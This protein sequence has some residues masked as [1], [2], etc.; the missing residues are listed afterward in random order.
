MMNPPSTCLQSWQRACLLWDSRLLI[1]KARIKLLLIQ[2]QEFHLAAPTFTGPHFEQV[3][4]NIGFGKMHLIHYF[5]LALVSG[6]WHCTLGHTTFKGNIIYMQQTQ[7]AVTVNPQLVNFH[8]RFDI[9]MILV[10]LDT[11]DR[12]AAAYH[13]FC[14]EA[15][16]PQRGEFKTII[17]PPANYR[18]VAFKCQE[19]NAMVPEITSPIEANL[20]LAD[21]KSHNTSK[22]F[23]GLSFNDGRF[24]YNS[25]REVATWAKVR[26]CPKCEVGDVFTYLDFNEI[27]KTQGHEVHLYY[28]DIDSRLVITANGHNSTQGCPKLPVT[29]VKNT[30]P[31]ES[32]LNTIAKHSCLRDREEIKRTNAFLRQEIFQFASPN[33]RIKRHI[34]LAIGAGFLGVETIHSLFRSGAP[35]S[36]LGKGIASIFGFATAD[37]MKMTK[38]QL[39][40]HSKALVDLS[41]NQQL[42]IEAHSKVSADI[43]QLQRYNNKQ[44]HD[45]AVLYAELD[46]KVAIYNLQTLLQLTLLKMSNAVASA[47]QHNTSPYVFGQADLNNVTLLFRS[48]NI[49]LTANLNEI[50]TSLVLVDNVYTFVFSAPIINLKNDFHFYEIRDLPIYNKNIQYKLR[51]QH[52]YFAINSATNEYILVTE[53]EYRTCLTLLVCN[54]AAPFMKINTHAPCEILTLKYNTQ[55]CQMDQTDEPAPNFLTVDNVTYYSIPAPMEIHI[56]CTDSHLSFDEHK[57]IIGT[58]QIQTMPGCN[59]QAGNDISVRPGF[60]ASR[61]NLESDTL[62]QILKV[63]D[64][65]ML[66][67]TTE[68]E[69]EDVSPPPFTFRDVSNFKDAI[70]IIFNQDT[71]YAEAIRIIVYISVIISIL[72]S[73]YCCFPK[74][75]LWLNGCCFF[76]KPTKYWRD[77]KG[78]QVPDFVSK[79]RQILAMEYAPV[80]VDDTIE[81]ISETMPQPATNEHTHAGSHTPDVTVTTNAPYPFN[82]LHNLYNPL[83]FKTF[84]KANVNN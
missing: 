37:D 58:G 21:M 20:L 53:T 77:V 75:R 9:Q 61:H 70:G 84:G 28:E 43:N 41:V 69:I 29:C 44:D 82:T 7:T 18:E 10:C 31:K 79:H 72:A 13:E 16:A 5:L 73:I 81:I 78:Y 30:I 46:N 65:A 57:S 64:M 59:I 15:L 62:F 48:K 55:H 12:F 6:V 32:L 54:V 47:T 80:K 1:T 39:E 24:T 60:V 56:V 25:N 4:P 74:V 19:F 36:L 33:K 3:L 38:E 27:V 17:L 76:Q 71:T 63:P 14:D 11:L 51:I 2:L 23:A 26:R 35:F 67:P 42:L 45:V 50:Y 83:L 52:R 40:R 8:R 22:T 49:P 66:Y 68:A 34:G